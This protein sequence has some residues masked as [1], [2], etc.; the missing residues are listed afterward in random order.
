MR[1]LRLQK[2]H[3]AHFHT[4]TQGAQFAEDFMPEGGSATRMKLRH[5]ADSCHET[6]ESRIFFACRE[7][8]LRGFSHYWIERLTSRQPPAMGFGGISLL[9]F[10]AYSAAMAKLEGVSAIVVGAHSLLIRI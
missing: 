10:S 9:G 5:R 8:I 7:P 2:P 4:G 6:R 3:L 1:D